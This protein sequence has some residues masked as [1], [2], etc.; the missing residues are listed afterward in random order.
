MSLLIQ[1]NGLGGTLGCWSKCS[2]CQQQFSESA[3]L[4]ADGNS[5]PHVITDTVM[6]G[7]RE[8]LKGVAVELKEV[9]VMTHAGVLT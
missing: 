9:Q 6:E 4:A 1:F 3:L 2:E 8:I 7:Q 5:R